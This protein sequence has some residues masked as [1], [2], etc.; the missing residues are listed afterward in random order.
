MQQEPEQDIKVDYA[1]S[2]QW[3]YIYST[4]SNPVNTVSLSF[5]QFNGILRI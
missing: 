3:K 1:P 2:P 4:L 5:Y